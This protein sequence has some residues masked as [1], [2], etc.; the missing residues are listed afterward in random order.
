LSTALDFLTNEN[1]KN[2]Y[3]YRIPSQKIARDGQ[4]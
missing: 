4:Y 3:A 1:D 2:K